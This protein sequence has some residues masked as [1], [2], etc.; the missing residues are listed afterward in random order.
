[1]ALTRLPDPVLVHSLSFLSVKDLLQCEATCTSQRA[2]L[3]SGSSV[4]EELLWRATVCGTWSRGLARGPHHSTW[5]S[6]ATFLE[7]SA[8]P[9]IR[10]RGVKAALAL[11]AETGMLTLAHPKSARHKW[12]TRESLDIVRSCLRFRAHDLEAK[13]RVALFVCSGDFAGAPAIPCDVADDGRSSSSRR[14]VRSSSSEED[15]PEL[16]STDSGSENEAHGDIANNVTNGENDSS[17]DDDDGND[18]DT[19]TEK[20]KGNLRAVLELFASTSLGRGAVDPEDALRKL[21]LEFPFLPIDAG[22]GADRC[23]KAVASMYL[24]SHPTQFEQLRR[25]A[26]E[27]AGRGYGDTLRNT[28]DD[29]AS[30]VYILLYAVIM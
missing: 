6:A 8:W 22:E 17:D 15:W 21:L 19:N 7:S 30:A 2:F 1:M 5:R 3:T 23:I 12:A 10:E 27:S 11:L 13:R 16:N 26:I 25:Q 20:T 24:A 18:G 9:L 4:V 28:H 29:P 14:K